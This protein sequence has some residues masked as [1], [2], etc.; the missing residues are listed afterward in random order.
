MPA[1]KSP[2]GSGMLFANL[3][4]YIFAIIITAIV[5]GLSL[6]ENED[7]YTIRMCK[8]ELS[9][10]YTYI[11]VNISSLLRISASCYMNLRYS[12]PFEECK[13]QFVIVFCPD[14]I[15]REM[16][17]DDDRREEILE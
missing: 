14:H 11:F 9:L 6:V 7:E 16:P 3:S 12:R 15:I 17:L 10:S 5:F 2:F 13:K 1:T 8:I 4:A